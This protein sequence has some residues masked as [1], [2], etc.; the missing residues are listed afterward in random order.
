MIYVLEPL[1]TFFLIVFTGNLELESSTRGVLLLCVFLVIYSMSKDIYANFTLALSFILTQ[2]RDL[3]EVM[4]LLLLGVAGTFLGSLVIFLLGEEFEDYSNGLAIWQ[5]LII[6]IFTSFFIAVVYYCMFVDVRNQTQIAGSFAVAAMYAGLAIAFP[7]LSAGNFLKII[8]AF[9]TDSALVFGSII[10][11][12]IG[13]VM[14]GMCYKH[15][16]CDNTTIKM[17]EI[18]LNTDDMKIN[19]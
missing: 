12:L 11:Q 17:K 3:K 7:N 1:L 10:G 4:V 19:F 9:S 2:Y 6:E 16:I 14:G 5:V 15:V 8:A 18:A 13:S